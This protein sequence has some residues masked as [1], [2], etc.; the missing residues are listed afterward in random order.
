MRDTPKNVYR[1]FLGADGERTAEKYLKK[2]KYKI[3]CRNYVCAAGEADLVC[4]DGDVL[5]FCEVK[6]REGDRFG[7]GRE[8]VTR[9][10]QA[11]YFR[12]AEFFMQQNGYYDVLVRFDVIEIQDGSIQHIKNAF[13]G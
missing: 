13:F 12:I 4:K 1:K 11:K 10:K 2:L 3:L 6:T 5:V 7:V 8:S 9:A